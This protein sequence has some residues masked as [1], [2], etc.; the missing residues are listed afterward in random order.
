[1]AILLN[2]RDTDTVNDS[3]TVTLAS[4]MV[5]NLRYAGFAQTTTVTEPSTFIPTHA[6]DATTAE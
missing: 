3:V 6:S 4:R 1:M 2:V 5:L